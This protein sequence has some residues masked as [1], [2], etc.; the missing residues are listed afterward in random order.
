MGQFDARPWITAGV[1]L[2]A[3][4]A[5]TVTPVAVKLPETHLV[6]IQL[7]AG[8][9]DITI[10][11]VRHGQSVDNVEGI[12]GTL[13]PGAPLTAEGVQQAQD[14]APLIQAAFPN[15]IDAIYASELIRTQ[16]TAQPLANL[17]GMNINIL[18]GLNEINAGWLEGSQLNTFTELGYFL[19]VLSWILGL[20]FVPMLGSTVNPNGMAFEDRVSDAVQT[21]YNA[22]VTDPD[23]PTTDVAFSHAGT[24]AAWTL[25][26]VKNPDF[27]LALSEL[28]DTH[29]PLPNTG[30]VVIEGNP[31]DGWT[32]VSW[33]GHE[34]GP[35]D[36]GTELFLAFRN[37]ITAPQMALWH[38]CES[39][40]GP[41]S[42][43]TDPAL[44][45][46]PQAAVDSIAGALLDGGAGWPIPLEPG[47]VILDAF[48]AI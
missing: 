22:T 26:N 24:I 3:A 7:V 46:F 36:L 16:E 14:V 10:D 30:Q 12:L 25:M 17:L 11:F 8:E 2:V 21:I 31:D 47:P 40:F 32:L 33:N 44:L 4:G 27:G 23:N 6:D 45:Q 13:P 38:L 35:A 1:A 43:T 41:D 48:S 34:V 37:L 9:A 28:I 19:P 20:Y 5:I 15:G 42:A 29:E 39:I 18:P